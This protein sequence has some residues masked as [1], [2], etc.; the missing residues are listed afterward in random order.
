MK[1]YTVRGEEVRRG[2]EIRCNDAG[3]TVL[4]VGTGE[5]TAE[6][7]V[8]SGVSKM[9]DDRALA[10][11]IVSTALDAFRQKAPNEEEATKN[12][13]EVITEV[14]GQDTVNFL[15]AAEAWTVEDPSVMLLEKADL[16]SNE[17]WRL[18]KERVKTDTALV[19]IVTETPGQQEFYA[20]TCEEFLVECRHPYVRKDYDD[21][22]SAGVG[23]AAVGTGPHGEPQGLILMYPRS[24]FRIHR[25]EEPPVLVVA[26]PGSTL[27]CFAPA[28]YR[29]TDVRGKRQRRTS[30]A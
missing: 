3:L 13:R 7:P 4:Q 24:S 17:P 11:D 18:I 25:D 9:F 28:K 5:E 30:A 29:K 22:P 1:C 12:L 2:L 8:G 16:S 26:W 23:V 14:T 15:E 21:F 20:N 10:I 27:R 6:L 19:H